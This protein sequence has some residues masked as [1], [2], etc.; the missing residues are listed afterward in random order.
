MAITC[1]P[2]SIH[3]K[4]KRGFGRRNPVTIVVTATLGRSLI[5]LGIVPLMLMVL[6]MVFSLPYMVAKGTNNFHVLGS[7]TH[8]AFFNP[9]TKL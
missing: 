2:V 4:F 3:I 5:W 6:E 8:Q 7:I 9:L 1:E